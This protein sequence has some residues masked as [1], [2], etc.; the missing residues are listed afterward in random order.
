MSIII[1]YVVICN[2][3]IYCTFEMN[4][5]VHFDY[6]KIVMLLNLLLYMTF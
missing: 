2:K 1:R 6:L 4:T 5:K 3:E